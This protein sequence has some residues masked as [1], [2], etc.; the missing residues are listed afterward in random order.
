M[1]VIELRM[2]NVYQHDKALAGRASQTFIE[3]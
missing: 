2:F 1:G 3:R